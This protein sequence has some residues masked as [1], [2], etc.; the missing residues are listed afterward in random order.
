MII[1]LDFNKFLP[2][3]AFSWARLSIIVESSSSFF[4]SSGFAG[5]AVFV[6]FPNLSSLSS[7][8]LSFSCSSGVGVVSL[9]FAFGWAPGIP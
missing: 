6:D 7:L 8:I 4:F 2:S 9:G 5:L 1:K 3:A